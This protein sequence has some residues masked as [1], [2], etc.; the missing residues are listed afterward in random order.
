MPSGSVPRHAAGC[1]TRVGIRR[2]ACGLGWAGCVSLGSTVATGGQVSSKF[3][4]AVS[5]RRSLVQP[6]R[7]WAFA[8]RHA[9]GVLH[10][11]ERCRVPGSQSGW[12]GPRAALSHESAS[13]QGTVPDARLGQVLGTVA[14]RNPRSKRKYP[15]V[16]A[17]PL[18]TL[19]DDGSAGRSIRERLG[20]ESSRNEET[21]FFL[22]RRRILS[23]S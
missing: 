7:L 19:S 20:I 14:W 15:S 21:R 10:G 11:G 22:F 13:R 1:H 18:W 8:G 16:G 12:R 9:S 3:P 17:I 6:T 4:T 5:P 23:Q 2:F